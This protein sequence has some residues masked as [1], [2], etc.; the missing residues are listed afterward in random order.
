MMTCLLNVEGHKIYK[1]IGVPKK[2]RAGDLGIQPDL[3]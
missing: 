1:V 2:Q 3:E